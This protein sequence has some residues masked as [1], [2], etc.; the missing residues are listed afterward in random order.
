MYMEVYVTHRRSKVSHTL[1]AHHILP[2]V[3]T[4]ITNIVHTRLLNLP[5]LGISLIG[6][7]QVTLNTRTHS[8][9][10]ISHMQIVHYSARWLLRI[11]I[12]QST[13]TPSFNQDLL[14]PD[15]RLLDMDC[16]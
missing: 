13:L 8:P 10:P 12:D 4:N 5:Y 14:F 15:G 2:I 9:T 11:P 1:T 6:C 16:C 3:P 7:I